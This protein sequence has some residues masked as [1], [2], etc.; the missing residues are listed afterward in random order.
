MF[1]VRAFDPWPPMSSQGYNFT[2]DAP[3][4]GGLREAKLNPTKSEEDSWQESPVLGTSR[5]FCLCVNARF[6]PSGDP[7]AGPREDLVESTWT[8]LCQQI[9]TKTT[10]TSLCMQRRSDLAH[11]MSHI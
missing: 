6:P 4:F 11:A 2:A 10:S 9:N 7:T 5:V 3:S 1:P 8:R